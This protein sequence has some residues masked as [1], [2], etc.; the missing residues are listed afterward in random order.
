MICQKVYS[1]KFDANIK[2]ADFSHDGKY[3]AVAS[4]G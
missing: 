4:E 1:N 2:M 3:V